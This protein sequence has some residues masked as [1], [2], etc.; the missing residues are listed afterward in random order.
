VTV[1]LFAAGTVLSAAASTPHV[2]QDGDMA[3]HHGYAGHQPHAGDSH[4]HNH[5]VAVTI[6]GGL[7][8]AAL[9]DA[10]L[11]PALFLRF[12]RKP[13]ERLLVAKGAAEIISPAAICGRCA[14][15][16]THSL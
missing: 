6:F 3:I 2:H 15:V 8:S 5:P 4:D 16:A 12:G 14:T 9:I 11:T 10:F 13:L 1:V 7:F